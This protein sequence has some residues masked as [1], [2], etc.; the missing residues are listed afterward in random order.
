MKLLYV[1]MGPPGCGKTTFAN[2]LKLEFTTDED[3]IC[4]AD[5]YLMVDG[6]YK[7]GSLPPGVNHM[8]CKDKCLALMKKSVSRV[9]VANTNTTWKEIK[10]Y[11]EMASD[12]GYQVAFARP[13]HNFN[14]DELFNRNVHNVPK[15]TLEAMKA[16]MITEEQLKKFM[17]EHFPVVSSLYLTFENV[18]K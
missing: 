16:R 15:A 4:C 8:K 9:I 1:I 14:A 7:F 11:V 5:D 2:N 18:G 12:N 17:I 10:P 13:R 3:I 6:V